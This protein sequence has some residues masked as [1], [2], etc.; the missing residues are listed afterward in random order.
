VPGIGICA[1]EPLESIK[2]TAVKCLVPFSL[3]VRALAQFDNG[4]PEEGW[5]ANPLSPYPASFGL[6]PL[7]QP[8]WQLPNQAGATQIVFTIM[9]PLALI[10]RDLDIPNVRLVDFAN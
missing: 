8:G 1:A 10:R 2:T 3:P 9:Q 5:G 7:D 4:A 6:S